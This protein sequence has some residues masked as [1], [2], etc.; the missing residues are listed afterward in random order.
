MLKRDRFRTP[1]VI[2]DVGIGL[3][4]LRFPLREKGLPFLP[5][6]VAAAPGNF[7]RSGLRKSAFA[8][9][10]AFPVNSVVTSRFVS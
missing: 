10:S 1:F 2:R 5:S 9:E 4:D 7:S 3:T 8:H 6:A